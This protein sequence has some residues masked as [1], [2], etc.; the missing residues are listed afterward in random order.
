MLRARAADGSETEVRDVAAGG[1][2]VSIK[3]A[4]AGA[5]EGTLVGFSRPP[6]VFT[7]QNTPGGKLTR[8]LVDGQR[9]ST[10][11]LAPGR[12]TIEAQGG[13]EVDAQA[14]EIRPGETAKVT[15]RNRGAGSVEG[16]VSDLETHAPLAG[17]RCDAKPLTSGQTILVPPDTAQQA[18]TDAA[19]HYVVSAPIGRVRIFCAAVNGE[20]HSP[21]G[22]DVEVM[23]TGV[24]K[25]DAV[26][27]HGTFG[28][29]PGDAGFMIAPITL[30]VTVGD[31]LP[32]G[33]AA[34]AG[35]RAGDQLVTIDGVSLRGLLPA[36]AMFLVANHRPGT[37]VTLG[38]SRGGTV[39][40]IKIPVRKPP[41]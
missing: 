27:V 23:R 39:Q 37:A 13:A 38:V 10:I 14:V 2:P 5:I 40:A 26:S 7:L 30:P 25:L 32:D 9:F 3:L 20:P 22:G 6:D 21:A 17:L 15:L 33:P 35:L 31:V 1:E 16:T 19:G 36:G 29:S 11:G 12:Y 18:F 34:V 4:R 28:D 8:A 24:A 41:M